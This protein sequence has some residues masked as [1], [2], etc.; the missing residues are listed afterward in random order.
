MQV[1][2]G[3]MNPSEMRQIK[4]LAALIL[5]HCHE[6]GINKVDREVPE[7]PYADEDEYYTDGE[8]AV[9]QVQF[10][11]SLVNEVLVSFGWAGGG[12]EA[13]G[14]RW[15]LFGEDYSPILLAPRPPEEGSRHEVIPV[16]NGAYTMEWGGGVPSF[17]RMLCAD[18]KV[19]GWIE[20]V[21]APEDGPRA[22]C[23][24]QDCPNEAQF[25]PRYTPQC[26]FHYEQGR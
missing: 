10:L 21:A 15:A 1:G 14:G 13:S 18:A 17:W 22:K 2:G 19:R 3:V 24:V 4:G 6:A 5:T 25:G 16:P 20:E 12:D 26:K 9:G 8:F 23:S 7:A 11:A